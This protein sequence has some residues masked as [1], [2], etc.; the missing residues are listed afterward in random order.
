MSLGG[1]FSTASNNAVERMYTAGVVVTTAAGYVRCRQL[2]LSGT[3][4]SN[5]LLSNLPS[6]CPK[7]MERIDLLVGPF[8]LLFTRFT[9]T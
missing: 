8:I 3:L 1:G 5:H 7:K 4:V 2:E 6:A 9:V